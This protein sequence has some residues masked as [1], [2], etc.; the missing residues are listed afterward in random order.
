MTSLT[1]SPDAQVF[2]SCGDGDIV[3][4]S[5]ADWRELATIASPERDFSRLHSLQWLRKGEGIS[6]VSSCGSLY[7]YDLKLS[8]KAPAQASDNLKPEESA[9]AVLQPYFVSD[10]CW[11]YVL[12]AMFSLALIWLVACVWFRWSPWTLLDVVL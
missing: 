7:S 1:Y 6:F 3:L 12:H 9:V 10:S 5:S 11:S 2:A 8:A 4:L